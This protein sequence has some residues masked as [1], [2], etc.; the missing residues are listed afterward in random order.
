MDRGGDLRL[1]CVTIMPDHAH[2]LF[3]L[4][5]RLALDRVVAK[6]KARTSQPLRQ[7]SAAWQ[8]NF[9]EH[10]LRV[11]EP[12]KGYARYIFL[13]PYRKPLVPRKS[14]WPWWRVGMGVDFDFVALL[15]EGKY[16]PADWLAATHDELGLRAEDVG[17]D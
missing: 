4:G 11:E 1:L 3:E 15:E 8:A 6:L 10:L 12:N 13:N 5:E 7:A 14:T 2:L 17:N 9:H 16:P